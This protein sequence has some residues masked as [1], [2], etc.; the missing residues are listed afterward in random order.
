MTGREALEIAGE[1]RR[2]SWWIA[3]DDEAE[4]EELDDGPA[5]AD[6]EGLALVDDVSVG[7][8]VVDGNDDNDEA[9]CE[10]RW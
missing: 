7:T 1:K 3:D 8:N 5:I 9:K 6:E 10:G 2:E 4:E